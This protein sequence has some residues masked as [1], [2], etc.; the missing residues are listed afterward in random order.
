MKRFIRGAAV[1]VAI[2][3]PAIMSIAPSANAATADVFTQIGS[4]TISPGLN[5]T[6]QPQTFNFAGSG[7]AA[8]TDGAP[9]TANCTANGN[10]AVG[11]IAVG[12]GNATITCTIGSHSVTV[13]ATFVR[14]GAAVV[15]VSAGGVVQ[16]GAGICGFA[17][18]STSL[19]IR[20]YT[21]ACG[22]AYAQAP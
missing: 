5:A 1:A 11:T 7:P 14:V 13:N 10:D 20:S 4:G 6:P 21:L 17:T 22:A 8:G 3:A 12:E 9:A 15:V 18:T 2:A 16:L 19:P